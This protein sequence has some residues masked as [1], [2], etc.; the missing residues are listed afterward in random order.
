MTKINSEELEIKQTVLIVEDDLAT[1]EA[2]CDLLDSAGVPAQRFA[3]AEEF[4][5]AWDPSTAG[6]LVLDARLPGMS[7]IE[8]QA[9]LVESGINVSNYRDDSSWRC[10]NGTQSSQDRRC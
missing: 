5:E 2:L 9:R 8:L 10:A 3:S 1:G 4:I 7:G 6:C